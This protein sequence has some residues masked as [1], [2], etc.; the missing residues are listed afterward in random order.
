[1]KVVIAL[2]FLVLLS[3]C[4]FTQILSTPKI[5]PDSAEVKRQ[6]ARL[7]TT[8]SSIRHIPAL[9]SD[10]ARACAADTVPFV[11]AVI[12]APIATKVIMDVV[13]N[14]MTDYVKRIKAESSR[15]VAFKTILMSNSLV[16]A[17]CIA[18]VRGDESD[19]SAVVVFQ[20]VNSLQVEGVAEENSQV[21]FS[22]KGF[23]LKPLFAR[24]NR[25]ISLTKCTDNCSDNTKAEGQVNLVVAVSATAASGSLKDLGTGATTIKDMKI[26]S[27]KYDVA[28]GIG[29]PTSLF[30]LP[31]NNAPVQLSVS[32][33]DMGNVGGDPDIALGEIQ[34]VM[35]ALKEGSV[36]EVGA[37]Y[38]DN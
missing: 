27:Q 30:A 4:H 15:A 38:N 16:S 18:M 21:R 11:D 20:L 6:Q 22:A 23:Y 37:H 32:M 33:A 1:M 3:G 19:P 12:W 2:S 9:P 31:V 13:S 14:A 28:K 36:A 25:A 34:A 29:A 7:G 8:A 24:L 35:A 17:K 26:R 5:H 10:V